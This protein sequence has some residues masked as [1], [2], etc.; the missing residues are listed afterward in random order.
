MGEKREAGTFIGH[1]K[2]GGTSPRIVQQVAPPTAAPGAKEPATCEW[3]KKGWPFT[4]ER[5]THHRS[6]FAASGIPPYPC[7]A[8]V[9]GVSG[10]VAPEADI[11]DVLEATKRSIAIAAG[12][13]APEPAKE[14]PTLCASCH[15]PSTFPLVPNG[16]GSMV[17]RAC[18]Q[19]ER[20]K[21]IEEPPCWVTCDIVRSPHLY[22]SSCRGV[23]R[24]V[25]APEASVD[26]TRAAARDVASA[27][28]RWQKL[29]KSGVTVSICYGPAK[30][31]VL[32]FSVDALSTTGESFEQP[33]AADSFEHAVEIAERESLA[34]GWLAN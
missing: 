10:N 18:E 4:D 1:D 9:S 24:S 27:L 6:I 22:S 7:S 8:P 12:N 11:A 13:V 26:D 30:R 20:A 25:P 15:L 31:G 2:V 14:H 23:V 3:C 29:G 21:A 28:E 19:F 17:C 33:F 5:K 34:R 32:G 16:A